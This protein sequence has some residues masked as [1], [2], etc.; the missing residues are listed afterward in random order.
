M[1]VP[2]KWLSHNLYRLQKRKEKKPQKLHH[3]TIATRNH[4]SS[5]IYSRT[6][7]FYDVSII[8]S[9]II[10]YAPR[11]EYLGIIPRLKQRLVAIDGCNFGTREGN[12]VSVL[13]TPLGDSGPILCTCI[14]SI[15]YK[16]TPHLSPPIP[17]ILIWLT[18]CR[19]LYYSLIRRKT[20]Q[21]LRILLII[22]HNI[23]DIKCC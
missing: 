17:A 9:I 4:T 21:A 23:I 15:Q 14:Y 5:R 22:N 2:S 18:I 12:Q 8:I 13:G 10:E 6:G 16:D 19:V 20:C 3:A 7:T 11:C 1:Q